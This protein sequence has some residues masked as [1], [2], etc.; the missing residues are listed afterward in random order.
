ME[1]ESK[2]KESKALPLF[3]EKQR[4]EKELENLQAHSHWLEQELDTRRND[5][6]RLLQESR[7][8]QM[9]LQTQLQV[10]ETAKIETETKNAELEKMQHRLQEQVEKL[11][12]DLTRKTQ[13]MIHLQETTEL[14]VQEERNYVQQQQ[15]QLTRWENRYNDVVRENESL[16][17]AA[18]RA[19]EATERDIQAIKDELKEKYD[20]LL[21]DQQQDYESRL[22]QAPTVIPALP[23]AEERP[24][25]DYSGL[26]VTDILERLEKTKS[27][28]R[29]AKSRIE[30]VELVNRRLYAEI[31]EKTPLFVRQKQEYEFAMDQNEELQRRLT[32]VISDK[33]SIRSE[34]NDTRSDRD[35]VEALLIQEREESKIL[36]KQVQTL[37]TS[38]AGADVS[39]MEMP[40][41]VAEMQQQNQR[42]FSDNKKLQKLVTDLEQ[43]LQTDELRAKVR[44]LE[45]QLDEMNTRAELLSD[46]NSRLT[47]QR[48]IYRSLCHLNDTEPDGQS[49]TIEE[50]SRRQAE[51]TKELETRMKALQAEKVNVEAEVD[52]LARDKEVLEERML[53]SETNRKEMMETVSSLQSEGVKVKGELARQQTDAK[54]Y[55]E[56]LDRTEEMLRRTSDE[57]IV[58]RNARSELQRINAELQH[59]LSKEQD[60]VSQANTHKEQAEAKLR[61]ALADVEAARSAERRMAS[62]NADLNREVARQGTIIESIQRIESS[63]SARSTSEL[64]SLKEEKIRL[65]EQLASERKKLEAEIENLKERVREGETKIVEAGKLKSKAEAELL[66]AKK[67]LLASEG[68]KRSIALK[69]EDAQT[70]LRAANKK[71]GISDDSDEA[72]V[73]LQSRVDELSADIERYKDEIE[74]LQKNVESY[75][76]IARDTEKSYKDLSTATEELKKKHES[77]IAEKNEEIESTRKESSKRR[78]MIVELTKDLS[79][80]RDEAEQQESKLKTEI[81]SLRSTVETLEK[82]VES[83]KA[84]AA[85]ATMDMETVRNDL[86]STQDNYERELKLHSQARSNLRILREQAD[87]ANRK[88]REAEEKIAS[89]N[90]SLL[91]EQEQVQKKNKEMADAVKVLEQRL[92]SSSSQN[93]VLYA[94]LETLNQM[95]DKLKCER[96]VA[97]AEGPAAMSDDVQALQ[98]QISELREVVTILRSDNEMVQTQLDTAKRIVDR[99]K[100]AGN[101]L[102]SSLAEVRAELKSLQDASGSSESVVAKQLE[103]SQSKL[104]EAEDQLRLLRDSNKVLREESEK[105]ETLAKQ[106]KQEIENLKEAT[107]PL[108]KASQNASIRI[109][110]LEAEKESLSRDVAA[111]KARVESLVSKFNQI[112]PEEHKNAL[113]RVEELEKEK[114]SLKEWKTTMEKE[115]TRIRE[116]ARRFK[117]SITE[118]AGTIESQKKEIAK[119]NDEKTKLAKVSAES[120]DLTKERDDLKEKLAKQEKEFQST[121]TELEGANNMNG[122]LRDRL[123][124]FQSQIK[125]LKKVQAAAANS[126]PGTAT[127]PAQAKDETVQE[128]R[129]PQ[130]QATAAEEATKK[131]PEMP[132]GGFKFGPSSTDEAKPDKTSAAGS[133][134]RVDAPSFSPAASAMKQETTP[135][136]AKDDSIPPSGG[137][138]PKAAATSKEK[139]VKEK[140]LERKLLLEKKRKLAEMKKK[141]KA[142]AAVEEKKDKSEASDEQMA[143]KPRT[144]EPESSEKG[145][146]SKQGH[147]EEAKAGGDSMHSTSAAD[148]KMTEEASGSHTPVQEENTEEINSEG[149][150]KSESNQ[151]SEQKQNDEV[152]SDPTETSPP[153]AQSPFGTSSGGA[154]PITFGQASSFGSSGFAGAALAGNTTASS[155]GSASSGGGF[156]GSTLFGSSQSMATAA[157]GG[158]FL[159][160]KPPG[161]ANAPTFS[162]GSSSGPITLPTP[163]LTA[164]APSPF[165]AFGGGSSAGFG[166]TSTFGARPLFDTSTRE[167]T[168]EKE[169]EGKDEK[170]DGEEE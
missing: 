88:S 83:A 111:W 42:L 150:Y 35:R 21:R 95:V 28:L 15:N 84:S 98:K 143:K 77:D 135:A 124:Q 156:P 127:L 167:E 96:V 18:K 142:G 110:Q 92:E 65:N 104:A 94:Q 74:S 71:L 153:P 136:A 129:S 157:A 80:Q 146:T 81:S 112:D 100:A 37:L 160:M 121:K 109:A 11:T 20:K 133:T 86:V 6:Q 164:P 108:E 165:G 87:E 102:R 48:D 128:K 19:S 33:D 54:Y 34:L 39:G 89:L 132:Q 22:A 137:T 66:E 162:F 29:E 155:F 61:Q 67:S 148:A 59:S 118:H 130:T 46:Q 141:A 51:K 115:N 49:L 24:T 52:R 40:T 113:K 68:E 161:S 16:K 131:P 47:Q 1:V 13:E 45:H 120:S 139:S 163:T 60:R 9:Q 119:L 70:K 126:A 106:L 43:E 138:P 3:H 169:D 79:K 152:S 14:E 114:E 144:L 73:S 170:E 116:I 12:L 151:G 166:S 140:L 10:N 168:E 25:E 82:D 107:K 158:S 57:C 32:Q 58:L 93:K 154:A 55:K 62:E 85:A 149:K 41:T 31:E 26:G 30:K 91:L 159:N 76:K 5:F 99:E 4:L 63:L 97:A 69:F 90:Q 56:K 53:R 23:S 101:V 103:E 36:A 134:L 2:L 125:E 44:D 38:R 50:V 145:T 147:A 8:R 105:S 122:R 72:E 7:D 27:E 123:R 17:A 64:E 75:K 78:E 117:Q